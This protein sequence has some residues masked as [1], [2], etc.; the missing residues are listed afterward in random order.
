MKEKIGT[1]LLHI[2]PEK[3]WRYWEGKTGGFWISKAH[4]MET[5]LF[6]YNSYIEQA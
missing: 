6:E 1:G 2:Y 4:G 5:I 3:S